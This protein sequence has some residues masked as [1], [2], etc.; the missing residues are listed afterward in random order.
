MTEQD[1]FT[2]VLEKIPSLQAKCLIDAVNALDVAADHLHA[3]QQTNFFLNLHALLSGRAQQ[4]QGLVNG[5]FQQSLRSLGVMF[6]D[7]SLHT[8]DNTAALALAGQRLSQLEG[9]M[10]TLAG[11]TEEM[12]CQFREFR[13]EV[14]TRLDAL[15]DRL[16]TLDARQRASLHMDMVLSAW[17]S[18]A[19]DG[20]PL[21]RQCYITLERLY[22]GDFGLLVRRHRNEADMLLQTLKNRLVCILQNKLKDRQWTQRPTLEQ[23]NNA[24]TETELE[25]QA[26]SYHADW[27]TRDAAPLVWTVGHRDT[28]AEN[29]PLDVPL[30]CSPKRLAEA[31]CGERFAAGDDMSCSG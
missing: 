12:L 8:D 24:G 17:E 27:A 31:L 26:I 6:E 20:L 28:A 13:Q 7:I 14:Q 19:L 5:C 30:L 3:Q 15:E 1:D 11:F 9:D 18:T 16:R 4:R 23:W 10:T 22:W 2:A 25:A 29:L 21:A